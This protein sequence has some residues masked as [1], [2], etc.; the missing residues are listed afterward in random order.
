MVLRFTRSQDA[1]SSTFITSEVA[2]GWCSL[3]VGAPGSSEWNGLGFVGLAEEVVA[4]AEAA[5]QPCLH[6][7]RVL[8]RGHDH[9]GIAGGSLVAQAGVMALGVAAAPEGL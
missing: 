6:L 8:P 1:T 3:T 9:G 7:D 4:G 5:D 2:G